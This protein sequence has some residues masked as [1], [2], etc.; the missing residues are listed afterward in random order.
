MG[1]RVVEEGYVVPIGSTP[2][3]HHAAPVCHPVPLR[4][5]AVSGAPLPPSHRDVVFAR[6]RPPCT[7][8]SARASSASVMC[9]RR[10][11]RTR[12]RPLLARCCISA[13]GGCH[14]V[15]R[16][17]T[18]VRRD[19]DV[20]SDFGAPSNTCAPQPYVGVLCRQ[21]RVLSKRMDMASAHAH[22]RR[23]KH[24]GVSNLLQVHAIITFRPS[25]PKRC[26]RGCVRHER[27][28]RVQSHNAS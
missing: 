22:S 9:P 23:L 7:A 18:Y 2:L 14:R 21:A 26:A 11:S 8:A 6:L 4:A 24:Q 16:Y 5:A 19:G 10:T 13:A 20:R 15:V 12:L 3:R 28:T 17:R 27:N 25:H 1:Q